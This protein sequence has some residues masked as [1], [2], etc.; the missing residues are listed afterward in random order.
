MLVVR[1]EIDEDE[2]LLWDL[3][4][5]VS[6]PGLVL[7]LSA[8]GLRCCELAEILLTAAGNSIH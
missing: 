8:P 4:H 7:M 6:C 2:V 5:C 3:A 1:A